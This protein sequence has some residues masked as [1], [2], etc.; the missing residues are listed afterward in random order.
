MVDMRLRDNLPELE[1]ATVW[2]NSTPLKREDLMG[3]KPL[4]L[5]FWSI[6]C[7]SCKKAMPEINQFYEDYQ[8]VLNVI[9]VH[10]PRSEEDID[11]EQV[12]E[13]AN[14]HQL[15]QPIFVDNDHELTD[16]FRNRYVPTYY[17]FDKQGRLRHRQ[18]GDGGMTMLARRLNRLIGQ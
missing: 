6:S 14:E 10:M 15:N 11:I 18:T 4:L 16:A 2:L 17:L 13:V 7:E 12:Q 5:Y 1:G 8:D 9:A 3:S